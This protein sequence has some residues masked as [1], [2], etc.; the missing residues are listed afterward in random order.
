M[1]PALRRFSLKSRF[2]HADKEKYG[3]F[4]NRGHLNEVQS[5]LVALDGFGGSRSGDR[6]RCQ[7]YPEFAGC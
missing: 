7:K 6:L 1:S 2:A 5:H 4:T 3:D